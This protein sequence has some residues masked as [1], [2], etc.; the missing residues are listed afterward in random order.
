MQ[1]RE[2]AR[3]VHEEIDLPFFEVFIDTPLEVC[4]ERDVKGLY[5]MALE[6]VL[7][8]QC[9]EKCQ[10]FL[11]KLLTNCLGFI[12]FSHGRIFVTYFHR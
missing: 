5:K 6:G 1:D 9:W 2:L 10:K 3:K 8:S 11:V 7:K 4:E 12:Y